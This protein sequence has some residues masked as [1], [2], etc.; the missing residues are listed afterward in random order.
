MEA[1]ARCHTVSGDVLH[2]RMKG[3]RRPKSRIDSIFQ[4]VYVAAHALGGVH[5]SPGPGRIDSEPDRSIAGHGSPTA[6][7]LI[8]RLRSA[9]NSPMV[10]S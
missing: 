10:N 7:K 9:S 2:G 4:G 5:V 8:I 3:A 6:L 1:R